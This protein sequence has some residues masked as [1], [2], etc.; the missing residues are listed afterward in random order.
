MKNK[1]ALLPCVLLLGIA[2]MMVHA[3]YLYTFSLDQGV[4]NSWNQ[5]VETS[6]TYAAGSFSFEAATL[7]ALGSTFLVTPAGDVDGAAVTSVF[8]D[9]QGGDSYN[10]TT[11]PVVFTNP[12]GSVDFLGFTIDLSNPLSPGVYNTNLAGRCIQLSNDSDE[13][14][15]FV[16]SDGSLTITPVSAPEPAP[17]WLM[18][19]GLAGMGIF[20]YRRRAA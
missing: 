15:G 18:L 1:N 2:P 5:G 9:G 4:D 14:C 16:Y 11:N 10:F 13:G 12:A 17:A 19:L 8:V 20:Q 6:V 3:S 7:P